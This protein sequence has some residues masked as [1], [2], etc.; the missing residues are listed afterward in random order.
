VASEGVQTIAAALWNHATVRSRVRSVAANAEPCGSARTASQTA[1]KT[2][3][4][5]SRQ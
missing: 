4:E 3:V 2:S 5:I 1:E